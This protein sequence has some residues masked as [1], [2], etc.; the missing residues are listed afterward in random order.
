[1]A[2]KKIKG[3]TIEIGA[4][5]LGLDEALKGVEKKSKNAASELREVDRTIK[6]AG[7]S[8]TLWKQKQELLNDALKGS[9]EKLQLL[10]DA[11]KKVNEQFRGKKISE[12]QYRAFQR[13]V[14][15]ARSSVDKYE[16]Q[17]ADAKEKV[18]ELGRESDNAGDEIKK[19]GNEAEDVGKKT[20]NVSDGGLNAMTV[21]FGTLVA[22]GI[23][24]AASELKD[25]TT[26]VVKTGMTF[27]SSMSS[28]KAISGATA[29]EIEQIESKAKEMGA[30]TRYTAAES[31]DAFGYM[32]LAGWKVEDMLSGIDGVLSLAAA[33]NMDLAQ[34][35]DIVTDYL[36]A[37]GL[38]AQ[39][40]SH[41]V[42]MMT[43]AMANSN[44][45][46]V[47]LG[48][49]YKNCA[50]TA[51][52]MGYSAEE[53][54]AVLMTMANAGVKGGEAGTALNAIMT[55]LA[56]DTK[57]CATE[58]AKYGV[59]VYNAEGEMQSL[60]SILEG[61]SDHWETLTDQEQ[62]N[63]AKML[64]GTNQYSA[65]QTIMNGLSD[66]AEEAGMSFGDYAA[67]LEKCDGAATD[68]STT[69][70]DNLQG[71]MTIFESAVDGM[72]LSLS[73]EL[74]PALRD[75]TQYVI[76]QMPNIEKA[77][78]P[79]FKTAVGGLEFIIKNIP[80]AIDTAKKIIPVVTAIGAA[81]ATIK[82]VDSI[83]K[84][85][86]A[87][88]ALFAAVAANPFLAAAAGVAAL[89]TAIV[90]MKKEAKEARDAM[91]DDMTAESRAL[92]DSVQADIDKMKELSRTAREQIEVDLSKTYRT[93]S[94]YK[95]LQGLV[96]EN[97]KVKKGYEDRVSYIVSELQQ[98]T[99][100]EIQLIDGVIQKY[101][102]LQ[103]AI[104]E[105]I[106]K[107]R[108]QIF[109]KNYS[110][111][112]SEALVQNSNAASKLVQAQNQRSESQAY[113]DDLNE[114]VKAMFQSGGKMQ[115]TNI[116]YDMV[117]KASLSSLEDWQKWG[118]LNDNEY[119]EAEAAL[120][121]IR[122]SGDA[123]A[124]ERNA[125]N[126]NNYIIEQYEKA[127]EA[128]A[129][130]NFS[131]AQGYFAGIDKASI[132]SFNKSKDNIDDLV[133][134]YKEQIEGVGK[135][136]RTAEDNNIKYGKDSASAAITEMVDKMV[137]DGLDG[138]EI[139]KTGIINNLS[140]IDH[141][142]TDALK[143]FMVQTGIDLGDILAEM[144][145]AEMSSELRSTVT[146]YL[147]SDELSGNH[148][149]N[150]NSIN[151]Q[152][153]YEALHG[154]N[155]ISMNWSRNA[156]G[157]FLNIGHEGIIAEAGPE[158]LQVMNGG[159]KVTPLSRTATN[160]PVGAGGDTV[161]NNYYNYVSAEVSNDY[162]VDR[163]AERLGEAEHR[164]EEGKGL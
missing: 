13:E 150:P 131:L 36:T 116:T 123:I 79:V 76:K 80:K 94:L 82:I 151:S 101:D 92:S 53:T 18:A 14:E 122:E 55:R 77:L 132:E 45:T 3:I 129:N 10:E 136:L 84:T 127:E 61:V 2:N 128:L 103:V 81:F 141:F 42:D 88:Q 24:V 153:D 28:V 163:L 59:N 86:G 146:Q 27:E 115:N 15:Y 70:I 33:S 69:M 164:I 106:K 9:R 117:G 5:T 102:E 29:S 97:G 51:A 43:Y 138:S 149:I 137:K 64:A 147:Y 1:M 62:A 56:T 83:K 58:L 160:T 104:Q 48:E 12:E 95:E 8:V 121:N 44:T 130:G 159:V 162:D 93:E 87:V 139:L 72:K 125:I 144:T 156:T 135:E 96:D 52:S 4:D 66:S 145:F 78:K 37:F 110:E 16:K 57:D 32:A 91:I 46:T 161:I 118:I 40:S 90:A 25:F 100:I 23:R 38:T 105:T 112:Y 152:S 34:A 39:D 108:A 71:D 154:G 74:N 19:F 73:E 157:N 68:M 75:I 120:K 134:Y 30:T 63:L 107:Q 11:Q 41:F 31:A 113:I 6:T 35:S 22:D 124:K 50:A 85:T 114:R 26:D 155:L 47:L 143:E 21:A 158:L 111:M 126:R 119:V 109:E 140:Q 89:V 98:A 60:S 148:L 7:D 133:E 20:Q 65:L 49:A 142:D 99:G 54:T 67:A 17:L